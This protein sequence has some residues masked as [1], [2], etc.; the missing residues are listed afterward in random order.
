ME[1]DKK[2]RGQRREGKEREKTH[3]VGGGE[4]KRK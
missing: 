4:E 2:E 3:S 1:R